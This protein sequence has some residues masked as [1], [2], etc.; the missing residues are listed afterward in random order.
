MKKKETQLERDT[1]AYYESLSGEVLRDE[2][3]LERAISNVPSPDVDASE[4]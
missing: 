2:Q 3:E 1:T 4:D